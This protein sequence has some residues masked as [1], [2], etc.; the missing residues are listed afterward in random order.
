MFH[1]IPRRLRPEVV[2]YAKLWILEFFFLL[3]VFH[4]VYLIVVKQNL[5]FGMKSNGT[6][7]VFILPTE[8]QKPSKVFLQRIS[9]LWTL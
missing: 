8:E 7:Q 2:Y 3:A 6:K 1:L 9:T 5:I 4:F